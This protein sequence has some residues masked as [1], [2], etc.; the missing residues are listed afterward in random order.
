MENIRGFGLLVGRVLIAQI[1]LQSGI[2]KIFHFSQTSQSMASHN[3]HAVP[4]WLV[5]AILVELAGA[6]FLITGMFTRAGALLLILFLVPVT[7]I[8]HLEFSVRVQTIMFVK[9]LAII[10]GLFMVLCAGPGKFS[11]DWKRRYKE[12]RKEPA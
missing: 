8:F 4:M 6:M 7:F 3:M 11:F 5:L 1:F 12:G 10:G 9:N 2:N